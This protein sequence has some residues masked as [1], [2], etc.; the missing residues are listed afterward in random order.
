M[1]D[2][3]GYLQQKGIPL[4]HAGGHEYNTTCFF[5]AEDPSKRGRLYINTDPDGEIPGAFKCHRCDAKGNLI[6]LRRHFGDEEDAKPTEQTLARRSEVLSAAADYYNDRL[7]DY[8]P[9]LA[10]LRGP[11]R[12]LELGTI[13]EQKIGYAPANLATVMGRKESEVRPTRFLYEH[14][15]ELGFER[16]EILET[17]LCR[18]QGNKTVDSLAGMVTI[19]Y[20]YN[21]SVV[22]IRGRTWPFDDDDWELW[23]EGDLLRYEPPKGKY[24]TCGG[25]VQRLYNLD[26]IREVD[27]VVVCEGEADALVISQL[28]LPAVGAPGAK[29]WQDSWDYYFNDVKRIWLLFDRDEAGEKGAA[30]IEEKFGPK[31]RRIELSPEGTKFDPTDWVS[32]IRKEG[33]DPATELAKKMADSKSSIEWIADVDE[34]IAEFN[35]YQGQPGLKFGWELLDLMIDPGMQ[36]AQLMIPLAKTG[37][38]TGDALIGVNRAGN[39]K[40]MRL[41]DLYQHWKCRGESKRSWRPDIPTRIQRSIDGVVRLGEVEE[42]WDSGVKPVFTVTTE[43]GRSITATSEH[44]FHTPEGWKKLGELEVGS[45]VYVNAGRS[46]KGRTQKSHYFYRSGL[47][48]HPY[49]NRRNVRAGG[50]SVPLHRLVVESH[51]N[52]L[53]L[54]EFLRRCREGDIAS[55]EFLDPVEWAVHHV[56]HNPFNNKLDNLEALSHEDHAARHADE[57]TTNNVLEQ[58]GVDVVSSVV[59]AGEQQTYDIS[60]VDEP[61]NFIAN[62]FVV[63]NTG[64]TVWCLNMMQRI[65]M[66]PGQSDMKMLFVSLEQTRGEW[67]DR[68]RRIHR[69]YN[70][71]SSEKDARDWWFDNIIIADRNRVEPDDFMRMIDD[72]D[73]RMG[74]LP[75]LIV[76]DYL[77]YFARGFKG[78]QYARVSDAVMWLKGLVKET[79]TRMI[80]PHQVS[81]VGKDGEEF[82]SDAA[83]DSVVGSTL[84][85]LADGSRRTISS[86][87]GTNPELVVLDNNFKFTT[88]KADRVW[89]KG[90]R[91]VY[92]V[93]LQ[94][95]RTVTCTDSHP[96]FTIHGWAKLAD[97][98]VGSQIATPRD[99]PVQGSNPRL[100]Y[101]LR[102]TVGERGIS[103]EVFRGRLWTMAQFIRQ[104][105]TEHGSVGATLM[106]CPSLSEGVARDLCSLLSRFGIRASTYQDGELWTCRIEGSDQVVEFAEWFG[107]NGDKGTT[108][109]LVAGTEDAPLEGHLPS[110]ID[111]HVGVNYARKGLLPPT[112]PSRVSGAQALEW[113]EFLDDPWL[114]NLAE[115]HLFF[116]AIESIEPAGRED[117]FDISVVGLHNFVANDIVV[118]NSGVVEETGDFV[119]PIWSPDNSL[120]RNEAEKSGRIH[121]RIAKSR[122]GGRGVLL[123]MQW[124]PL[125]LAMVPEGDPMGIQARREFSWRQEY[126][127]NWEKALY[128]HVTGFNG[129]IS[130]QLER[131]IREGI[132]DYEQL[133]LLK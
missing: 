3:L 57:G 12:G 16:Q 118:K 133:K 66:V 53:D 30:K 101:G 76:V 60:M 114:R 22:S 115:G 17:G 31:V 59:P 64:K 68:A 105:W 35:E 46:S 55:L 94:S 129:H 104:F 26:S 124:A 21:G 15:R 119:L 65:R 132:T 116:E 23:E 102:V 20:F 103:Q 127:D 63:H 24:K 50:N 88:R 111:S 19:P 79:K 6:T 73:Y 92:K 89:K 48:S 40:K 44:P 112:V 106:E 71:E 90:E 83:R 117:V 49:R 96:F 120:N 108:L 2:I 9:A 107:L 70:L 56:D 51:L 41:D 98:E 110:D 128:R 11:K 52:G 5:C 67:W 100:L 85:Q 43:Q 80:V 87:V 113:A 39:G 33:L 25:D 29:S 37:C 109:S 122:H 36:P 45:E 14:L 86:L 125:S 130:D 97:L 1:A 81:R 42:V 28:G 10:Y 58:V 69:F 95:G 74:Q 32:S 54:D 78:E 62:E 8:P 27:E 61:H 4:K 34:A 91:D 75:D 123:N 82:G 18:P 126:A 121:A 13:V 72:F 7:G 99:L 131:R 38:I 47:T 77:G 93:T 84:V